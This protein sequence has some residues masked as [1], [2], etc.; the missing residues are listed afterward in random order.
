MND[1]SSTSLRGHALEL[2][3]PSDGQTVTILVKFSKQNRPCVSLQVKAKASAL[4]NEKASLSMERKREG[5]MDKQAIDR[6]CEWRQAERTS[7]QSTI[8][9]PPT[10]NLYPFI[11]SLTPPFTH[12]QTHT[13]ATSCF[14]QT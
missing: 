7:I 3:A 2:Q 9:R 1:A 4:K 8:N 6:E 13:A 10:S 5:E 11:H 12:T 14:F